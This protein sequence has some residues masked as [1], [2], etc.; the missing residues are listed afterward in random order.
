MRGVFMSI[1]TVLLGL[2]VLLPLGAGEEKEDKYASYAEYLEAQNPLRKRLEK[3]VIPKCEFENTALKT[4]FNY[5]K[6]QG[7][8][9]DE[10][11][12]G[13]NLFFRCKKSTLRRRISLD[14]KN[15][16]LTEVFYYMSLAAPIN[17]K[18]EEYAVVIMD[19]KKGKKPNRY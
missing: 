13:F 11:G 12:K 10:Q 16:P 4:V 8:L 17:F 15:V 1:L 3:I 2:G 6:Q 14:L 18:I 7:K 9:L 5:L 19:R